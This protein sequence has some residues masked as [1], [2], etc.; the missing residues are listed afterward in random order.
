MDAVVLEN[1]FLRARALPALGA[2]LAELSWR[3]AVEWEPILRPAPAG[4]TWFNDLAC[5]L[6]APWPNRIKEGC[7]LWQGRDIRL[8]RDW[9]DGTAIHGL[10]KQANWTVDRRSDSE[11]RLNVR[12]TP[13]AWPWEFECSVAYSLNGASFRSELQLRNL[14]GRAEG[15]MPCGIGFHPFFAR[16]VGQTV[17]VRA[18]VRRRYALERQLPVGPPEDDELTRSLRQ[19]RTLGDEFLDDVFEG[20]PDGT[21]VEWLPSGLR[22]TVRCS[23]SLGHTVIYSRGRDESGGMPTSFCLEPVSMVNNG[24]RLS[25]QG[26]DGTGVRELGPGE[27]LSGWWSVEVAESKS[28]IGPR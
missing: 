18:P 16:R 20:S 28:E 5:Y 13:E 23:E 22:A 8:A 15:P 25:A 9:P 4:V 19:G 24:F 11:V 14:S 2:G 17:R 10:V 12:V 7:F 26:W 1:R 27:S 21:A 6:L 3:R